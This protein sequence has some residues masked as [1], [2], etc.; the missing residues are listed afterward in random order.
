[1][2]RQRV[3]EAIFSQATSVFALFDQELRFVRVNEAFANAFARPVSAFD[4]M[5]ISDLL[6]DSRSPL[7]SLLAEV[8]LQ[9]TAIHSPALA[10]TAPTQSAGM[11]SCW[12]CLLQPIF[13]EEQGI[14]FVFLSAHD[15]TELKRAEEEVREGHARL[16]SLLHTIPDLIWV[17]DPDGVY[18]GCNPAFERFFGAKEADIVGKTDYAFVSREMADFFRANDLA[19]AKAG[20]TRINEE[21][22][23]F[24]ADGRRGLFETSK[25]PMYDQEG[26]LVG[27]LGIAREITELKQQQLLN[28]N[29][30]RVLEMI[31][32][33]RPL[34]ETLDEIVRGVEALNPE[35][36]GSILLL[37]GI[38]LRDAAGPSLPRAYRQAIDGKAIGPS[39]G[40]CGTA[41]YRR[42]AVFVSDVESDP[43]WADYRD[44]ARLHGLR[45]CW[46]TPIISA[47]G[48]V[49]GTFAI[50]HRAPDSPTAEDRQLIDSAVWL[51]D[52]A[53]SNSRREQ[54]LENH[55][56]NLESLVV[57]RTVDLK[58]V[59]NDL[60]SFSYGVAHDLRGPLRHI[61]GFVTLL[62]QSEA[63]RLT[64][65]GREYLERI[66]GAVKKMGHLIDDFLSLSRVTQRE[67]A[68]REVNVENV[69]KKVI[70]ELAPEYPHTQ[71]LLRALPAA[72]ADESLLYQVF[73]NLVGN[74][75]KYSARKEKPQVE[76]GALM[77]DGQTTYFVRDNGAGF[78][79]KYASHLFGVFRRL[80]VE[81]EFPG[82]GVG[83]AIVK[84]II[85]RFH[86]RV[87][88]EAEPQR[89]ATFYFTLADGA[90]MA[91]PA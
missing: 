87:W 62:G 82:T 21:R 71:V 26:K 73:S 50:Y 30:N 33:K 38:Y 58:R 85:D 56:Q 83:L 20:G 54:E 37:D 17:K 70:A 25:T 27:V 22:L 4:G 63:D 74:A 60:E 47:E 32:R 23:T 52:I 29:R 6:P 41:A 5:L 10:L 15:I 79:M 39:A 88:A 65:Q 67:L 43:L 66:E 51:A 44:L 72:V 64:P 61:H 80:H 91:S 7:P 8:M 77:Q 16:R 76:I 53:I 46:S 9:G 36:I 81:S 45:A 34:S 59:N 69:A 3:F 24:A 14:E 2:M 13:D 86:G 1:M 48:V 68:V 19:A 42:E 31:A 75:L 40:S 11:S 12:D 89:G 84:Q 28:I 55:R 18:M 49:L 90:A 78:D 57:E 35:L